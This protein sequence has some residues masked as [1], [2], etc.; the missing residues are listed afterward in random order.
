MVA[1]YPWP[2]D[3]VICD[4]AGGTGQLL[5]AILREHPRLRGVLVDAPGV[6][7]S[8]D[9]RLRRTGLSGRVELREGDIFERLD[10]RADVYLLKNILHDWDDE[11]L[12][13]HPHHG[14][15]RPCPRVR[16]WS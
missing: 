10:A 1:H 9:E 6:L 15:G 11:G 8:A 3:G 4:V 7:A 12:R 5:E 2:N 16:G 13:P 14:P